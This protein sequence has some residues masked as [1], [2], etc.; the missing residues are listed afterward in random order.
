MT[1]TY[2]TT[3]RNHYGATETNGLINPDAYHA[4]VDYSRRVA[5]ED[6]DLVTI[7]RLRLISDPGY[8]VW[9]VSYCH[10]RTRDGALVTV[11]LP[12]RTFPKRGLI[13][14]LVQMAAGAGRYG[15]GMGLLDAVSTC[16]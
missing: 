13:H 2:T 16:Q 11:D 4:E 14:A 3:D 1:T 10:G 15:K 12:R 6:H 8:P 5:F 9:D 7:E